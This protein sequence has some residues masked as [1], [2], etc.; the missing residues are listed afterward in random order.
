M[1]NPN[2][3]WKAYNDRPWDQ[4]VQAKVMEQLIIYGEDP[5]VQSRGMTIIMS[6]CADYNIPVFNMLLKNE[7]VNLEAKDDDGGTVLHWACSNDIV[8]VEALI[9]AGVE[10][11]V[12]DNGLDTPLRYCLNKEIGRAHV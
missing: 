5:N 10:L 3:L 1:N 11:S 4:D 12:V 7:K 2:S 6:C 9:K 8:F